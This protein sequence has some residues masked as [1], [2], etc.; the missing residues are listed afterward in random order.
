MASYFFVNRIS[1]VLFLPRINHMWASDTEEPWLQDSVLNP[2]LLLWGI[3][4]S[5]LFSPAQKTSKDEQC[6]RQSVTNLPHSLI[7]DRNVGKQYLKKSLKS[8][9]CWLFLISLSFSIVKQMTAPT[10]YSCISQKCPTF[11]LRH[12]SPEFL[13]WRSPRKN[14]I[15]F[16]QNL[17]G[18]SFLSEYMLCLHLVSISRCQY[19]REQ[20]CR[21]EAKCGCWRYRCD[22][23]YHV[24]GVTTLC[25]LWSKRNSTHA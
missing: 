13:E 22:F 24:E 6:F 16:L 20:A 4:W 2:R 10:V 3:L 25:I 14:Y 18:N 15:W 23:K 7:S 21:K 12:L 9:S 17:P 19:N 1:C 5:F 8:G 11:T